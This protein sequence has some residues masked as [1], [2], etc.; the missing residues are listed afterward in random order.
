MV[1]FCLIQALITWL[2]FGDFS[3]ISLSLLM[4]SILSDE[5]LEYEFG[6]RLR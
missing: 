2:E 5:R 4:I 3:R 6:T 1:D